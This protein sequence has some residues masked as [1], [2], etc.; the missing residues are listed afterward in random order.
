MKILFTTQFIEKNGWYEYFSNNSKSV[1]R[2]VYPLKRAYG[3]RFIKQNVPNIEMLEFPLWEDYVKRLSEGWDVVGFS[4]LT[5]HTNRIVK[6]A[7]AARKAGVKV[8]WGG[9]YGVTNPEVS[10][11]FDRTFT[12]YAEREVAEALAADLLGLPD[13]PVLQGKGS[14]AGGQ[15]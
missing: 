11:L 5:Q 3:I 1:F 6:M 7:E 9:N 14:K 13:A 12:G 15:V 8:L 4:F 10:G 2:L